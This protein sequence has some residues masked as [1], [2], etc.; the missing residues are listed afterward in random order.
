[1]RTE[2]DR[3][4]RLLVLWTEPSHWSVFGYL[5]KDDPR[6]MVPK[7]DPRMGWTMNWASPWAIPAIFGLL[8][9]ATIPMLGVVALGSSFAVSS[10]FTILA[11]FVSIPVTILLVLAICR[12]LAR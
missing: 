1:M 5:C 6:V 2:A 8:A 4:S 10:I 7:R 12:R 3:A 9:V 11:A